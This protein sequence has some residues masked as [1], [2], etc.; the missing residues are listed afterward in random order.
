VS[1]S[2]KIIAALQTVE[3][4]LVAASVPGMSPFWRA[5]YGRFYSSPTALLMAACVG[6]GGDK[7]RESVITSIPEVLAG[8]FVIPAGERH[9]FTHISENIAEAAKTLRILEQYLRILGIAFTRTGDTIDLEGLPRGWKVLACRVGAV[10]GWRCI[11]WTADECAKW[12]NEGA[13]PSGEVLASVRAMTVTHPN[14][15]GR[16]ISSPLGTDGYFHK[17]WS[18]GDTDDVV[19]LHAPSWVANPSITEAR[20][21][22]LEPHEPTWRREYAAQPQAGAISA[23]DA[24]D[25]AALARELHVDSVGLSS[26]A[27]FIDSSSGRGDG[28]SYA[29]AQ[30]IVEPSGESIYRERDVLDATG[31][32]TMRAVVYDDDGRPVANDRYTEPSRRLYVSAMGA[33]EGQF[34][35][36]TTLTEVVAHIAYL[37]RRYGISRVFGDQYL[38]FALAS[39]FARHQL[40][41]VE[42][43]WTA[44]SKIE[45]AATLRRMLRE[46]T[47]VVEPGA[48]AEALQRE[49]LSVEERITA[50]GALTIQARRSGAGHADRAS[51][52][53]LMARLE[54]EGE[55]AGSPIART[56]GVSTY[57]QNTHESTIGFRD[58][59]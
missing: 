18:A 43:A 17:V 40:A 52:L 51:L 39:E 45:A 28:W 33:F 26:G 31:A 54:S 53:M 29:V 15:R 46:R 23:F 56:G 35:R 24:D 41:F 8:D 16:M 11:G 44:P 7:S 12:S 19:T 5:G 1:A 9:Y 3:A 58:Y 30:Y 25:V 49:L 10:S 47:V 38:A 55:I 32:L 6:R 4:A 14:A 34:S 48:D 22:M 42:R 50:S 57:D 21:R 13:D 37:A 27:M 2:P 20:T 36:T 59:E